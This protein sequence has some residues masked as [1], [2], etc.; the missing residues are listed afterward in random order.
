MVHMKYL[1]EV[2]GKLEDSVEYLG[3]KAFNLNILKK[4][5]FNTP[6]TYV[7]PST[8]LNENLIDRLTFEKIDFDN[9][10]EI[11]D[12]LQTII[13]EQK[14]GDSLINDLKEVIDG[15]ELAS[16]AVRSSATLEDST[17]KSFAGQFDTILG[18]ERELS[19]LSEA[20]KRVYM[21][22]YSLRA[23]VYSIANNLDIS[24]LSMAV[25][26]QEMVSEPEVAGT[27]FTYDMRNNINDNVCIQAV[28]G[29][30][31][32]VVEG[33]GDITTY[34]VNK[35]MWNKDLSRV[36]NPIIDISLLRE[37]VKLS[38]KI[39][40]N[41]GCPQDIEWAVKHGEIYFLQTRPITTLK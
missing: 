28:K 15:K 2:D 31:D 27:L 38:L 3:G 12:Q 37:L 26:V 5:G 23:L 16:Y 33:S 4:Y 24:D 17:D 7:L 29:L 14:F 36:D 21:S 39:E 13:K 20:V 34:T 11:S 18:V 40:N 8:F 25:I 35:S 9:I 1:L 19:E 30:G 32:K 41:Y 22:L 6:V 10:S